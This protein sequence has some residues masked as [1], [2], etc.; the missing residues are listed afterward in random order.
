[1]DGNSMFLTLMV[2]VTVIMA[3]GVILII[4]NVLDEGK[5]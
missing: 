4:V 2:A 3:V 1:M 5:D